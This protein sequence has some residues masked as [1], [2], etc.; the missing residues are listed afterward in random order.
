MTMMRI[1]GSLAAL[2]WLLCS[3]LP[4]PARSDVHA[5]A[6]AE[7]LVVIVGSATGI[8]DIPMAL[9]RRAFQSEPAEY[10]SGKRLIPFNLAN[11]S[12]ARVRF[13]RALLGL[14][15]QDVARF[16]IN[17][18]IRGEGQ[19]PRTVPSPELA[20]R[21]V[22]SLPGAITYVSPSQVTTNVRVLTVDGKAH[23][24]PDYP[25]GGP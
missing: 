13:D 21:V 4:L 24:A 25:F 20:V 17:R 8:K 12:P 23:T 11:T 2:L 7:P 9:L 10:A 5:Q 22:A 3:F 6:A 16:W 1:T 18:R 14:E 15:P 19:P